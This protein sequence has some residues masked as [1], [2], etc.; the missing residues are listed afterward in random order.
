MFAKCRSCLKEMLDALDPY[1]CPCCILVAP[2]PEEDPVGEDHDENEEDDEQEEGVEMIDFIKE[3]CL[4]PTLHHHLREWHKEHKFRSVIMGQLTSDPFKTRAGARQEAASKLLG[5]EGIV[6]MAIGRCRKVA[7][8]LYAGLDDVYSDEDKQM[9]EQIRVLLELDTMVEKIKASSPAVV[10]QQTV[11]KFVKAAAKIDQDLDSKCD[12]DELKA[13]Y[14]LFI[15]KLAEVSEEK[16]S[17]KFSSMDIMKKMLATDGKKYE[18]CEMVIDLL[19]QAAVIKSVESVVESWISVLEHHSSKTRDLNDETIQTE[20]VIAVNGP[21]IQHC[22]KVVETTMRAYWR[23]TNRKSFL[24][25]HFV[26]KSEK[27]KNYLVS[28]AVDS[29]N[30]DPIKTPFM[31]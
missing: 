14:Q 26:R 8:Y 7:E 15:R 29:L 30:S 1:D 31:V 20:L 2:G 25:G 9:V 13:Q 4:W 24:E 23:M 11:K 10:A 19:C 3:V 27:I 21:A 17:D 16:Y 12:Q 5:E 22:D 6:K 28:K 18:G